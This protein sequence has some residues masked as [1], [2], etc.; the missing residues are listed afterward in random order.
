MKKLQIITILITLLSSMIVY[1]PRAS[2][3]LIIKLPSN[4]GLST[5]LVGHWTMDD[6]D[7]YWENGTMRDASGNGNTGSFAGAMST[8]TAPA[9]GRLGQALKFDGSNDTIQTPS[10]DLSSTNVVTVSFWA[11]S[12]DFSSTDRDEFIEHSPTVVSNVGFDFHYFETQCGGDGS[13]FIVIGHKGNV[14]LNTSCYTPPSARVWH[15]YAAIYNFGVT[16]PETSLYIDGVLQTAT[17]FPQVNENTGNFGNFVLNIGARN[18]ASNW[19]DCQMD[20]VRIYSR[21]LS[22]SE[23]R[24][25]YNIGG[26]LKIGKTDTPSLTSGLVG[27]WTMDGGDIYESG[28]KE[29]DKRGQG[30]YGTISSGVTPTIGRIGQALNYPPGGNE[31]Y[32]VQVANEANFDFDNSSTFSFSAWI[33]RNN[34]GS[35]MG[36]FNKQQASADYPGIDFFA[37]NSNNRLSFILAANVPG[38]CSADCLYV[39]TPANSLTNR[40]WHHVVVTYSGTGIASGVHI[41]IDGVD[42]VLGVNVNTLSSSILNNAQLYIGSKPPGCCDFDGKIDDARVYNR[43]LSTSEIRRLYNMGGTLKIGK[44]D[45]T[46]LTSGLVGHWTMDDADIYWEN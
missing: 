15:H 5:N 25:L 37:E 28:T 14:G 8:T 10:I 36:L 11:L 21:A 31:N 34:S 26:T 44:T 30:N 24:R 13:G 18:N 43:V 2:A 3:G 1:V 29:V 41:Y 40:A 4:L 32:Y 12:N 39:I 7:I 45:T 17:S 20:D 9:I 6:A 16:D 46:S 23:I 22:P 38:G 33:Y 35:D 27:H 42:Q 19:C